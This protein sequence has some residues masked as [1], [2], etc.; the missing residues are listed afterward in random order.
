L[1]SISEAR[2]P[3]LAV[4]VFPASNDAPDLGAALERCGARVHYAWHKDG[5]L[6]PGIRGVA[7]PGGFSFGDYLRPGAMARFSPIMADV[8]ERVRAGLPALGICNGFQILCEAGLLPGALVRN[9]ARRF[10]ARDVRVAL[11]DTGSFAVK[12]PRGLLTLPIKHGQGCYVR[13][14]AHPP[15]VAFRYADDNPNGTEDAIAGVTSE[16]GHVL[17]LMPHPE[18]AA[19]PAL[20]G[21]TDGA[22]VLAAFVQRCTQ[23]GEPRS[24]PQASEDRQGG[25]PRSSPQASE[26][27]TGGESC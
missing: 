13:D 1:P 4:L 23:G 18:H 27:R 25:E 15:R 6:P 3:Q 9:A 19:D 26:A 5:R 8:I 12:S 17:G 10:V 20:A 16:S 11:G 24:S 14:P 21:G 22:A 7:I 2:A